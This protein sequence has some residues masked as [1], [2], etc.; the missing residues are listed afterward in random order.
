MRSTWTHAFVAARSS[1]KGISIVNGAGQRRKKKQIERKKKK[2]N[3]KYIFPIVLIAL[4]ICAAIVYFI[5]KD[6]K[7][8]VY[9]IAAA[10]LTATVTF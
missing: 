9:W 8:G 3:P 4:D 1:R 7:H 10:I 6:Y 2:M 5:G